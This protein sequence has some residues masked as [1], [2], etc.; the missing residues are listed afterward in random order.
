MLGCAVVVEP[1]NE[2]FAAPNN[3][4]V[5]AWLIAGLIPPNPAKIRKKVAVY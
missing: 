5:V 1:N 3:P 2:G 4:P